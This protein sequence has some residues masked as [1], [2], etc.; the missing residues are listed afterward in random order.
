MSR[1]LSIDMPTMSY[2]PAKGVQQG[3]TRVSMQAM[4]CSGYS[5]ELKCCRIESGSKF[6]CEECVY[7]GT[8]SYQAIGDTVRLIQ[9]HGWYRW[10]GG[11]QDLLEV[12]GGSAVRWAHWVS[13]NGLIV[14]GE[15]CER[16]EI[17]CGHDCQLQE[18]R[19]GSK[20][21]ALV[22]KLLR[23]SRGSNA[24]VGMS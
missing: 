18:G 17:D 12:D 8:R 20:A 4:L 10:E 1:V 21:I 11:S 9:G 24:V 5:S 14:S 15:T 2:G 19:F 13:R 3:R 16:F 23:S 22:A 7:Q 6:S